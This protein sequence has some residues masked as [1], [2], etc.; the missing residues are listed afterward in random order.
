MIKAAADKERL[1]ADACGSHGEGGIADT[2][3]GPVCSSL[4]ICLRLRRM[5]KCGKT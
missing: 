1:A 2:A 4:L 5:F 3:D